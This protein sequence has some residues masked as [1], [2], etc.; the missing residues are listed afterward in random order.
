MVSFYEGE[1]YAMLSK[2]SRSI[3]NRGQDNGYWLAIQ[4]GECGRSEGIVGQ[5]FSRQVTFVDRPPDISVIPSF[6]PTVEGLAPSGEALAIPPFQA[7]PPPNSRRKE[8]ATRTTRKAV[9]ISIDQI[10]GG[11][12]RDLTSVL[13]EYCTCPSN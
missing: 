5:C 11:N 9:L 7:P 3:F 2:V 6:C 10:W 4:I 1:L 12:G 8:R 13:Y